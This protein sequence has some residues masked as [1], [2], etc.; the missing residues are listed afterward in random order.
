VFITVRLFGMT[1]VDSSDPSEDGKSGI[2]G[3]FVGGEG[4]VSITFEVLAA[5]RGGV[6][7]ESAG[8]LIMIGGEP[9]SGESSFGESLGGDPPFA[10][11]SEVPRNGD[12][13]LKP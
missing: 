10:S 8:S 11:D 2:S 9:V 7:R 4:V 13:S 3:I 5:F 12:S 1:G 6:A